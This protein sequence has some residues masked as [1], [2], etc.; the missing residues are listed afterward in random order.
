VPAPLFL[1][2]VEGRYLAINYLRRA[3]R[4]RGRHAVGKTDLEVF[5]DELAMELHG[6]IAG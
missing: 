6:P 1:K 5:P 4:R 2:E 3:V